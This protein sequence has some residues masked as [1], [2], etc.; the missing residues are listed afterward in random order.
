MAA[1]C[2]LRRKKLFSVAWEQ[3]LDQLHTHAEFGYRCSWRTILRIQARLLVRLLRDDITH[4]PWPTVRDDSAEICRDSSGQP[5]PDTELNYTENLPLKENIQTYIAREVNPH[6][7]DAWID[8]TTCDAKDGQVGK[9]GYEIPFN[10]Y[11]YVFQPLRPLSAI[12]ADLKAST[13]RILTMIGG[14]TQ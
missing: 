4:L 7:P 6:V 10:R 13:D 11:F 2:S 3:R 1:R 5:E 8:P 9:V 12:D 14:L